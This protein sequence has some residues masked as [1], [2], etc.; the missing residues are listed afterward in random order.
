MPRYYIDTSD[1]ERPVID[2]VGQE[3]TYDEAARKAALVALPDRARDE[4]PDG[5]ERTFSVAVRAEHGRAMYS[6]KLIL[7][8]RWHER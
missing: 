7:K 3:L 5:D 1:G 2:K 4:L 6:A 8:G